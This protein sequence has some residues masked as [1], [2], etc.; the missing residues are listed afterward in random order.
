MLDAGGLLALA[1]PGGAQIAV[2]GWERQIIDAQRLVGTL[3]DDFVEKD[4]AACGWKPMF[5]FAE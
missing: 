1:C 5:L 3:G 2:L 4:A